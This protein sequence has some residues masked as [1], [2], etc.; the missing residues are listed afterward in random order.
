MIVTFVLVW[1]VVAVTVR[2]WPDV[3]RRSLSTGAST[4]LALLGA[5]VT[6]LACA[7]LLP[8]SGWR[9]VAT[10]VVAT[11]GAGAALALGALA[12][13]RLL[14]PLR[15]RRSTT[16]RPTL[17][18]RW[19]GWADRHPVRVGGVNIHALAVRGWDR[20]ITVRVTGLAAEMSYYGLISLVPLTTAVGASLGSLERIL[21]SEQVD[22]IEAALVDA[23]SDVFSTQTT[24]DVL[25]PVI[26]G[27]L[28]E[29]RTGLAIGGLA[30]T[31]WLASRVFRAAIRALD[32]AYMVP[33]RRGFISQRMLGLA[34][35]L[36]AV[37][38]VV[39]LLTTIVVG[40][41]LGD[42]Q[43]IAERFGLGAAFGLAWTVLRW[44][45]VAAVCAGYLTLLY[46]YAPNVDTVWTRCLPG[47][48]LGTLGMVAVALGFGAYLRYASFAP[49]ALDSSHSAV[50]A[51]AS[52]TLGVVLVGVLWLWLTSIVVLAG[53]VLNA[54]LARIRDT[55]VVAP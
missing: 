54:E 30:L 7:G 4:T 16:E 24:G 18:Q 8:Q 10:A 17:L 49:G 29:E 5:G 42:G 50:T 27:L 52:Q 43:Q 41:L 48:V 53:G 14:A 32:D 51:A 12:N 39:A 33:Q 1:L 22:M 45:A 26:E 55:G 40:P 11:A 44:P 9:P 34:L 25:T 47:A 21:G 3:V 38:T 46:R 36:G 2:R 20:A 37:V 15:A 23:V 13:A 6:V 28:R 19:A 31:L 35:A